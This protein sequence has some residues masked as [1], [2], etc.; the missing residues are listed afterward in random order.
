MEKLLL[1][2]PEQS[3]T[4]DWN[5]GHFLE[6]DHLTLAMFIVKGAFRDYQGTDDLFDIEPPEEEMFRLEWDPRVLETPLYQRDDA[7]PKESKKCHQQGIVLSFHHVI[8]FQV[9]DVVLLLG[10]PAPFA[11]TCQAY[12]RVDQ[13]PSTRLC[14]EGN[15]Y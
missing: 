3:C 5:L 14:C 2:R 1:Y 10:G 13:W 6:S 15:S 12:W 9:S 11:L 8:C 4:K 7:L